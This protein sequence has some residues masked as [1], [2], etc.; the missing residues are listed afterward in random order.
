MIK[1]YCDRCKNEIP[2]DDR[3][4]KVL[5]ITYPTKG[6]RGYDNNA[7][8][9][10]TLCEKCFS[11]MGIDDVV[12]IVG[13]IPGTDYRMYG[14]INN[15]DSRDFERRERI[16]P[17]RY[18]VCSICMEHQKGIIR[19]NRQANGNRIAVQEQVAGVHK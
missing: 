13:A 12:K 1:E 7:H 3:E 17:G 11:E 19:A 2:V 8:A 16:N 10:V 5:Q 14:G 18:T 9:K 6:Y 4:K 15:E